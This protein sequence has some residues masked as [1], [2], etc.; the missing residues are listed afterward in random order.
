[1]LS[2]F[3]FF[4]VHAMVTLIS[5]LLKD[6]GCFDLKTKRHCTPTLFPTRS[7]ND[8]INVLRIGR[9]INPSCF[10][11]WSA[12]LTIGYIDVLYLVCSLQMWKSIEWSAIIG[13]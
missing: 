7:S 2:R 10:S 4:I 8:L 1:M 11:I 12:T 13:T 5:L 3:W 6:H 9:S